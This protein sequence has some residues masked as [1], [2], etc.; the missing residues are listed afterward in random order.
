MNPR[1]LGWILIALSAFFIIGSVAAGLAAGTA[2]DAAGTVGSVWPYAV[3]LGLGLVLL[4]VGVA[5]VG[6]RD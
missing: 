5:R 4:V 2:A 3:G 1:T 6:R